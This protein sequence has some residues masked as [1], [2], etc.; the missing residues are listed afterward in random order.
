M[1]CLLAWNRG[2][3]ELGKS[4][5]EE[6]MNGTNHS[7]IINLTPGVSDIVLRILVWNLLN[8]LFRTY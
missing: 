6:R 2:S 1:A 4:R 3:R 5:I 8:F 7:P